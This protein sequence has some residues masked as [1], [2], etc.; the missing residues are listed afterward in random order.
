V[1]AATGKGKMNQRVRN[2]GTDRFLP[3]GQRVYCHERDKGVVKSKFT[4][5]GKG[6]ETK[7]EEGNEASA[8]QRKT[9]T[10]VDTSQLRLS[11]KT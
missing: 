2:F 7:Q 6:G 1:K 5:R 4:Y 3:K 8:S 11:T 10:R 9:K